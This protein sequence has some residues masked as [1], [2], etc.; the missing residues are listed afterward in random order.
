M[1]EFKSMFFTQPQSEF[2]GDVENSATCKSLP[3][4]LFLLLES[5]FVVYKYQVFPRVCEIS[6]S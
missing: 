3:K 4:L 6:D 2:V 5:L 1:H